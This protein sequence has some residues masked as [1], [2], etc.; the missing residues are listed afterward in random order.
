LFYALARRP[1]VLQFGITPSGVQMP[2]NIS[3]PACANQGEL[4]DDVPAGSTLTC[5]A[6]GV[7]FPVTAAVP[8]TP[9][10]PAASAASADTS[11]LGVWV[12][13]AAV[14]PPV[15]LKSPPPVVTPQNAAA[16]LEWVRAETERFEL[17]VSRQLAV[18][19]KMRDQIA[20]FENKSRTEAV[21]KE[22]AL[23]RD[24]AMLDARAKDLD[25]QESKI[26]AALRLQAEELHAELERQ[27]AE[28]RENLAK[29]AEA[30]ARTERSLERRMFEL[31]ELEQGVRKE[32]DEA[33]GR[34][35]NTPMPRAFN[36]SFACG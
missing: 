22:Q 14:G 1:R 3:C 24:R 30:L 12:G 5:R 23:A 28:E 17:Y 4:P 34:F 33:A 26:S 8:P 27:V 32:L 16:H 2:V 21:Q 15:V 6:C 13:D 29:R 7:Q 18:L 36:T 25:V 11:G 31:E 20:A 10:T 19:A 9:P 35:A